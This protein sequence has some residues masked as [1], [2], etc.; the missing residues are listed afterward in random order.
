[1]RF[2]AIA[3][4][5]SD[6]PRRS[7]SIGNPIVE[8]ID[9]HPRDTRSEKDRR[10][11]LDQRVELLSPR[12]VQ[13]SDL[14]P[15]GTP[16]IRTIASFSSMY[17]RYNPED[18]M[19]SGIA[20]DDLEFPGFEPG[21]INADAPGELLPRE[22]EGCNTDVNLSWCHICDVTVCD[23][24]WGRQAAHG[25]GRKQQTRGNH[26]QTE[27]GLRDIINWILR[28]NNEGDTDGRHAMDY[29]TKWFG[30]TIQPGDEGD[31][32]LQTTPR[33]RELSVGGGVEQNQYPALISFVGETG[34][35]KSTLIS[36]LMKVSI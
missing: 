4:I 5:L 12:N 17:S 20:A 27:L 33:Y 25:P 32:S 14:F 36:A 2:L 24:C 3:N 16:S 15:S 35:G 19:D 9:Q 29:I 7:S 28:P 31:V 22:C 8:S 10:L 34:A 6:S 1:M 26:E 18:R 13:H 23:E 30:V 11:S 21:E